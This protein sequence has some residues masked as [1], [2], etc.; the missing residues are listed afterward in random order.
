MKSF[1]ERA[2]IGN[3]ILTDTADYYSMTVSDL[4]ELDDVNPISALN[5]AYAAGFNAG[6][7]CA[8]NRGYNKT[9]DPRKEVT[10]K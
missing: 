6:I 9:N 1:T 8:I 7:S 10:R 3:L 2:E 5:K 4:Y